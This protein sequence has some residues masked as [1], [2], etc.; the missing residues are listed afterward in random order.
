MADVGRLAGVSATTVS[1]VINDR[2]DQVISPLTRQRVLEAVE[3]L[4]YR[5]NRAAQ[6]LRTRRTATIGYIA[7]EIS[8]QPFAGPAMLGAHEVAWKQGCLLL[9]V[10][11]T[12]DPQVLEAGVHDLI[13]RGVDAILFAA[14]GTRLVQLPEA[15]TAVPTILINCFTAHN[16]LPSVLPDEHAGGQTATR[17]LLEAGHREIAFIGGKAGAWATRARLRGYREVLRAAGIDPTGQPVRFGDYQIDSGYELVCELIR[18]GPV[19]TGLV[20][21]ND[22]MAVGAYLALAQAGLRVPQ[23]VSVMGYDN[24]PFLAADVRPRLSTVQLP[25]HAMGRWAAEQV[26][27]SGVGGLPDRTYLPCPAV[28]GDSVAAP[29]SGDVRTSREGGPAGR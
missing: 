16:T 14:S 27:G 15:I 13:D 24:Q 21:G 2:A 20:C 19:P 22:R 9:M 1:F 23:D 5:P 12:H 26:L 11:A 3:Q 29:R 25:Y 8:L 18:S 10:D 7:D 4:G 17:Q 6:G 28:P